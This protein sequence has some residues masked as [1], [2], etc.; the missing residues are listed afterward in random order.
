MSK[1][2][3]FEDIIAWKKARE[4]V[5]EI[6]NTIE[7]SKIQYDFT[8]K[9]QIK[10]A[11]ISVMLNIAEGFG[12]RT[13]KEFRQFLVIS[14]GSLSEVQSAL[15]IALDRKYINNEKFSSLYNRCTEIS[16]TIMGLIKYL[17]C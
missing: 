14:H 11:A 17:S 4:F 16:K 8:L 13:D 5:N 15:Y 7:T 9:N 10:K 3:N 2:S 6:Y 12:R 1:I